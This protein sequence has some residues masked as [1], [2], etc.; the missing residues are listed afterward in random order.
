MRRIWLLIAAV[1]NILLIFDTAAIGVAGNT[2][3]ITSPQGGEY[4]QIGTVHTITWVSGGNAGSKVKLE[5]SINNRLTWTTIVSSTANDG[6]YNWAVPNAPSEACNIRITDTA[7]KTITNISHG[8]FSIVRPENMP[9]ISLNRKALYFGAQETGAVKTGAQTIIVNNGGGGLLH[10]K[11]SASNQGQEVEWLK[12]DN[13]SGSQSGRVEVSVEPAGLAVGTTG[14]EI[15]FTDPNALNSPQTVQV[16][17]QVY[18]TGDD[19]LPFGS[20]ETPENN[21]TVRSS[22]PVTGWV[23]DDIEID[24]VDIYRDRVA[25][26]TGSKVFIGKGLQVEGTRP[27]VEQ[28]YSTYP[29]SYRAGWGYMLLTNMLPN[30]GNGT[31]VLHAYSKDTAGHEVYLGSKIITC[32]NAHAVKPFGAIDTPFQGGEASGTAYRNQGW[33]LTPQPNKIPMDGSTITVYIDGKK[34]GTVKYNIFR[35][36]I[37]ALFPDYAN[38]SGAL[39]YRQIDTTAYESGLHTIQWTAVD[40]AGNTDGIGSRY[41]TVIQNTGHDWQSEGQIG[42]SGTAEIINRGVN[43]IP[44]GRNWHDQE[45]L[46]AI[47]LE[48]SIPV[49]VQTG[50]AGEDSN[51]KPLELLP[52]ET[53]A[54]QVVIPQDERVVI[55][56]NLPGVGIHS[57]YLEVGE[58]LRALPPGSIL[59]R[60]KG[61]FYWQPGP[62]SYRKYA[63]VFVSGDNPGEVV[64]RYIIVKIVPKYPGESRGQSL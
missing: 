7:D 33:V 13:L 5:Y 40:N 9:K 55:D 45:D 29:M 26:E 37:A 49:K 46:Q 21:S 39:A 41:F 63:L 35:S 52:D 11:V 57:G 12:I 38:S 60:E 64:R 54:L 14:G 28:A 25:G 47:P 50:Y 31:F 6:S 20:F 51:E 15:I 18:K 61:I 58:K 62:A 22:I 23:L 53:G 16:Y 34:I 32:D 42:E 59:D 24:G 19:A 30:N 2:L 8:L 1:M 27:D 36:D 4:W 17:V 48:L 10:W 56:L 3:T 44:V 43:H